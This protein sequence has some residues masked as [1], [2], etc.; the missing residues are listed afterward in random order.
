MEYIV[1]DKKED[2]DAAILLFKEYAAGLDIDLSFQN[3]D[4]ELEQLQTMYAGPVGG[5]VLCKDKHEYIACIGIRKLNQL[6]AEIKRMYVKPE[7]RGEK[8]GSE[9]V[10]RALQLAKKCDYNSVRLDT[11]NTMKPAMKLYQKFGFVETPAYYH[12]P[13]KTVV[14]FQKSI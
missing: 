1:A 14:Y 11:L 8:I 7:Y 9:L 6:T 13:N 5:I 10:K 4:E 2:Y 3:F 12:N